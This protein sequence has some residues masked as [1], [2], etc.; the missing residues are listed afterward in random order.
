MPVLHT[1]TA[2]DLTALE[3]A[4]LEVHCDTAPLTRSMAR[5]IKAVAGRYSDCRGDCVKRFVH[6][7]VTPAGLAL[8]DEVIRERGLRNADGQ[9]CVI[10]RHARL[11]AYSTHPVQYV[12]ADADGPSSL[13]LGRVAASLNGAR[14]AGH[15]HLAPVSNAEVAAEKAEKAVAEEAK[16]Q[17][18]RALAAEVVHEVRAGSEPPFAVQEDRVIAALATLD[19]YAL[20]RLLTAMRGEG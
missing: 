4:T 13:V 15:V 14:K 5:R 10:F 12:R 9:V 7:P 18:R 20:S 19:S 16:Q 8:A 2:D 11:R 1:L 17:R 6:L 3:H